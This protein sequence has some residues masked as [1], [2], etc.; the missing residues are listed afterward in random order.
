MSFTIKC[1]LTNEIKY[2]LL[3]SSFA[4]LISKNCS[5]YFE[6][7]TKSLY[8]NIYYRTYSTRLGAKKKIFVYLV[9]VSMQMLFVSS[10][11][12]VGVFIKAI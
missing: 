2:F 5:I 9:S 10:Y 8:Q 7:Q 11:N 6:S 12:K 4:F 1:R 3:Y